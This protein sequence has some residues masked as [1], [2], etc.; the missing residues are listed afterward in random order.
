VDVCGGW[1]EAFVERTIQGGKR[2]T[3]CPFLLFLLLLL[4]LLVG[5]LLPSLLVVVVAAAV[6][7]LMLCIYVEF[8]DLF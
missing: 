7:L 8:I 4:L 6:I 2:K 3:F 1:W 5:C